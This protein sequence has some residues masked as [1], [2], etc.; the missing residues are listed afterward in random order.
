MPDTRPKIH[1]FVH[2]GKQRC[3]QQ[4]RLQSVL[5]VRSSFV[6]RNQNNYL[7]S[8]SPRVETAPPPGLGR[9]NDSPLLE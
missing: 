2:S 8:M 1:P 3:P 9:V 4:S 5:G 7:G 6:E